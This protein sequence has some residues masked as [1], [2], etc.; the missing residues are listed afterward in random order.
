MRTQRLIAAALLAGVGWASALWLAILVAQWAGVTPGF[1]KPALT[2]LAPFPGDGQPIET[3]TWPVVMLFLT[4]A[5][6]WICLFA[7]LAVEPKKDFTVVRSSFTGRAWKYSWTRDDPDRLFLRVMPLAL[8]LGGLVVLA[9]LPA[10]A[11]AI[12]G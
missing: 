2:P 11:R 10:V 6:F 5:A 8:A 12:V 1:L 4:F 9:L 7:S 3:L